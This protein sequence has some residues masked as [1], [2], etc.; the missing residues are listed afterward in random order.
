MTNTDFIFT[1]LYD[2]VAGQRAP[3]VV[4]GGN[5]PYLL[6]WHLIPKNRFF[7]VM[8]HKFLRSDD[9]RALHCHPWMNISFLL[10]GE[11]TEHTIEA[12]GVH[13]H[14]IYRAGQWRFRWSGKLAHRIDLHDGSC[15]TLFITGPKY[16]EWGF[17]CPKG[18]RHW[19]KFVAPD[20]SGAIGKGC[21]D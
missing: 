4:I 6:R 19:E 21:N 10:A 3:D 2:Q 20:D 15:W 12:G 9:D 17:H 7:N 14:R 13:K 5:N 16:R 1:F 18:W 8:L 11:Y